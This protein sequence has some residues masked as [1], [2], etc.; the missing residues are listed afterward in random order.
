[1]NRL[2]AFSA[3]SE[4]LLVYESRNFGVL[5]KSAVEIYVPVQQ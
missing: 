2:V 3:T 5:L 1:M 4:V